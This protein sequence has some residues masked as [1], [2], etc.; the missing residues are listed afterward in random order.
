MA[1][2]DNT[3]NPDTEGDNDPLYEQAVKFVVERNRATISGIQRE[4]R[5]GYN[6]GARLIELMEVRGV[7]SA[8]LPDG[9]RNVL[10]V[11]EGA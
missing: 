8:L 4:F 3:A 10:A 1:K 7:V 9:S 11:A 2:A 5:I 6:R